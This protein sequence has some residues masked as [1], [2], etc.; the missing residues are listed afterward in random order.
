M[1]K[2]ILVWEYLKGKKTYAIGILM[3]VAG[4]LAKDDTLVLEGFG[5]MALRHGIK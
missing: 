3:I 4:L 5:F 2:L 1:D